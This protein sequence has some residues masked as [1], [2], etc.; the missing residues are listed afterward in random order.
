M[1]S[2]RCLGSGHGGSGHGGSGHGA[3]SERPLMFQV[4]KEEAEPRAGG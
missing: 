1:K 4:H 3:S 2:D